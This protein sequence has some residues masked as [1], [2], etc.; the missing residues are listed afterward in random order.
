MRKNFDEIITYKDLL[1][2]SKKI[3]KYTNNDA[4]RMKIAKKGR[5]KY[6]KYFNS[7]VIAEFIVNKTY[8]VNKKYFWENKK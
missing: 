2:L 4:L 6:F 8:N 7:T 5:D 3:E 1:D